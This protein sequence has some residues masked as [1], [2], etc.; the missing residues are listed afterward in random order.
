MPKDTSKLS[1]Q[2]ARLKAPRKSN[3]A[4]AAPSINTAVVPPQATG[5][6]VKAAGTLGS[7]RAMLQ[8]RMGQLTLAMLRLPRYKNLPIGDLDR[9]ALQPLVND[10]VAFAHGEDMTATPIGMAI[11]AS[12]SDAVSERIAG[13]VN[14]GVF[15]LRLDKEDWT[16]GE[17]VW[18]LDVVV[19]TK[20]AGTSV[21]MNFGS[22]TDG[23]SFR[24]HPVV[25]QSIERQIVDKIA[26]LGQ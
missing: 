1:K 13:Q 18:L 25:L 11:W 4:R 7:A 16:S 14:S 17:N 19:P 22:L 9:L 10:R 26:N 5:P 12:V 20:R 3:G 21:F 24:M 15:P 6:S 2:P 8:Q 23:R